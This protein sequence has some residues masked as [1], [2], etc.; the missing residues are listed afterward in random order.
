MARFKIRKTKALSKVP[1]FK[2]IP[3]ESIESILECTTYERHLKDAVLCTF[4]ELATEF[5]II[6][7]GSCA[8]SVGDVSTNN[9]RHVGTL[10]ELDFFGENALLE[11]EGKRNATVIAMTEN[12]NK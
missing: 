10:K 4:S 12:D 8:V 2:K 6:V 5:Y 7:S 9:Y 11:G 1:M 3:Q